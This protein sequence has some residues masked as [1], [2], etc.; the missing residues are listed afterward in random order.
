MH[1]DWDAHIFAKKALAAKKGEQ[2]LPELT[3]TNK[4]IEKNAVHYS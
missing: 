3:S 2:V 4:G 1:D